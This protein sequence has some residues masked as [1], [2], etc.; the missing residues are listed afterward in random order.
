M[1][2]AKEC[3]GGAADDELTEA[4]MAVGTYYEEVSSVGAHTFGEDVFGDALVM[5]GGDFSAGGD[6]LN[7]GGFEMFGEIGARVA[8]TDEVEVEIGKEWGGEGKLDGAFGGGTG[9]VSDQSGGGGM[10]GAGGDEDVK[11]GGADE[12]FELGT[13]VETGEV[14]MFS[15]L[16]QNDQGVVFVG[17]V[18][19]VDEVA[20]MFAEGDVGEAGGEQTVFAGSEEGEGAGFVEAGAGLAKVDE[21]CDE[22]GVEVEAHATGQVGHK[23]RRLRFESVEELNGGV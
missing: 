1:F 12:A 19:E 7:A 2:G 18:S 6:E 14:G 15:A 23:G 5:F 13:E 8:D 21:F 9:V 10:E 20:G 17:G 4:G 3:G 11:V 22:G 16:A